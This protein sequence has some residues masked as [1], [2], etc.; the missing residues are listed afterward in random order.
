MNNIVPAPV[1]SSPPSLRPAS[2]A[3]AGGVG[4]DGEAGL[5]VR[6]AGGQFGVEPLM[7]SDAFITAALIDF[8]LFLLLLFVAATLLIVERRLAET[9]PS[10]SSSPSSL[11]LFS[12]FSSF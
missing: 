6:K 1:P 10:S 3:A 8:L 9:H 5:S 4:W 11:S 7:N 2:P 12:T